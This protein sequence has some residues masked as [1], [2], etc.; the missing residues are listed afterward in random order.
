M[1]L[2][3]T[4]NERLPDDNQFSNP[5]QAVA[6]LPM[7]PFTDPETNL[8]TGTPPGDVNVGLYYNPRISIDYSDFVQEGYRNLSN[9]YGEAQ[10]FT[11]LTFRTEFGVDILNQN[12][13]SY[14]QTQT[15]RNVSSAVNGLGENLASFVANYNTNNYFNYNKMFGSLGVDAVLAC[16]INS[17]QPSIFYP[18]SGL[19]I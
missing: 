1:G 12:E 9:V 18:G 6:L 11:G 2:A 3:R 14:Y 7:T 8:P 13:E 10:L 5:L 17:R 4:Y 16:N 15:V 19:S